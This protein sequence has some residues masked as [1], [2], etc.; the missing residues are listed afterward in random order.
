[1]SRNLGVGS[2]L[3]ETLEVAEPVFALLTQV[4]STWLLG[5]LAVLL[6]ALGD[7]LPGWD[8]RRG[9]AVLAATILAIAL[10]GFLKTALALPRPPGAGTP[11]YSVPGLFGEVYTW[12]S[13]AD[14]FGV[15][16]GH[17]LGATAVYGTSAALADRTHR[18]RAAVAAAGLVTVSGFSRLALGVHLF[19]DVLAGVGVGLGVVW[20]ATR[21]ADTPGRTFGLAVP[22]AAGWATL[23]GGRPVALGVAA[24]SLGALLAW[25]RFGSRLET[26]SGIR[27]AGPVAVTLLLAGLTLAA[28][29]AGGAV[30]A[31]GAGFVGMAA[32][33][34][35][36]LAVE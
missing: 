34:A 32:V 22:V 20:V 8:R 1:M 14:G 21:W 16:S 11:A 4:G 17:A 7:V 25:H 33:V 36:P 6:Y 12:A 2:W 5:T 31:T 18:R 35:L 9:A 29:E 27:D 13:T 10:I 23:A 30:I 19:V 3:A 26:A 28:V 24:V 15:P